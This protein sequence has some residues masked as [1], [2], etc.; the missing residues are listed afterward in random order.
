MDAELEGFRTRA[1]T[2]PFPYVFLDATYV[3]ARVNKRVVS[4]AVV[5]AMGV[6]M[7]GN[8]EILGLSVGDLR[9]QGVLGGVPPG[10]SGSRP[11]RG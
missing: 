9:R 5:V 7:S 11:Q 10:T 2:C 4:R 3:K 1:F 6:S 8:R